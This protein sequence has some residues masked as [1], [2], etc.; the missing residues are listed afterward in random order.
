MLSWSA[1]PADRSGPEFTDPAHGE[2][3]PQLVPLTAGAVAGID[4]QPAA[5]AQFLLGYLRNGTGLFTLP[6]LAEP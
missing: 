4:L 3:Q 1:D 6:P 5:F 2:Y